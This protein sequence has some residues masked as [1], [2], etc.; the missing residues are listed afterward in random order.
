MS[1][2]QKIIA[3]GVP[4]ADVLG[5]SAVRMLFRVMTAGRP[6]SLTEMAEAAGLDGRNDRN[7]SRDVA[8]KMERM[9]LVKRVASDVTR[10]VGVVPAGK[11]KL[12]LVRG[13]RS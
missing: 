2:T 7:W 6:V 9:G 4:A 10:G 5:P 3:A 8:L 11:F 12:Q 13:K 1:R